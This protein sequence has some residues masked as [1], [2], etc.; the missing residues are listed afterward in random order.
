MS[1][2]A[3][4]AGTAIPGSGT[5]TFTGYAT[6]SYVNAAGAGTTALAELTVGANFGTRSLTFATTNTRTSPDWVTFTPNGGL[7]LTGTLTY[8]AGTNSFTG[9]VSSVSGLTGNS[10]GQFYGPNAEELGGVFFLKGAGVET[11]AGAY[12]AKQ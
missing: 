4:T 2:G 1:V 10:T 3:P 6:G 9:P 8:A 12:G 7:N 5:A 11:Y